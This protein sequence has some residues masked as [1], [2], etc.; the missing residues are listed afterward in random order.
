M[1][2]IRYI[3]DFGIVL[4]DNDVSVPGYEE[5]DA[6]WRDIDPGLLA[7]WV[8]P[9]VQALWYS[10]EV[11]NNAN[12]TGFVIDKIVASLGK[13]VAGYRFDAPQSLIRV[14]RF[15]VLVGD[16]ERNAMMLKLVYG[17]AT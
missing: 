16:D 6:Q 17:G 7:R 12:L 5:G 1:S 15:E 14:G 11:I 8:D 3:T 13:G 2:L 10:D 9:H 4:I